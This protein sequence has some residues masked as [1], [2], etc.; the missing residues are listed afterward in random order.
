MALNPGD[1]YFANMFNDATRILEGGLWNNTAQAPGNDVRYTNDLTT[2]LN[3]LQAD[4]AAN[5][6]SG[7]QLTHINTVI[8]DIA[9][10]STMS[11]APYK[12][13]PTPKPHFEPRI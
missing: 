1:L 6:F 7:D 4:A 13:M 11:K 12:I 5:D 3:G 9:P 2:V 8:N 10:L